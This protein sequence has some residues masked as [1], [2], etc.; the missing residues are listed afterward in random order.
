MPQPIQLNIFDQPTLNTSKSIKD[1]MNY[2]VRES[3][4]S[5]EQIVDRMNQLAERHGVC[6]THGN[7]KRLT[8]E[9]F[10]KWINPTEITRQIPLKALPIFCAAVGRYSAIGELAKP[11]GLQV[12][13]HRDQKLLSWAEAKMAIKRH[14]QKIRKLEAEL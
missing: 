7:S 2:D 13:S 14:G 5:R 8:M 1:A 10:E 6:L 12:I 9:I 4:L 11:L 3:N